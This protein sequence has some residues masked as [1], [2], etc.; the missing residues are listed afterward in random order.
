MVMKE[1]RLPKPLTDKE[2]GWINRKWQFDGKGR[3]KRKS[4]EAT[5]GNTFVNCRVAAYLN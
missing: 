3:I 2:G 4:V 5:T 1:K